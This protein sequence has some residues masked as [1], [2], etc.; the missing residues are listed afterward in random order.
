MKTCVSNSTSHQR[1]LQENLNGSPEHLLR[2]A[3]D[4][5]D[6]S[7]VCNAHRSKCGS[8]SAKWSAL[9]GEPLPRNC[10]DSKIWSAKKI[11]EQLTKRQGKRK[12]FGQKHEGEGGR[13][14]NENW[15][16]K[17]ASGVSLFTSLPNKSSWPR[18]LRDSCES[19]LSN[20]KR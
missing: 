13:K 7:H 2:P 16:D 18:F 4:P 11:V 10:L 14:G 20:S 17:H 15:H 19:V 6:T 3:R 9:S 8:R 5:G 1:P 12:K